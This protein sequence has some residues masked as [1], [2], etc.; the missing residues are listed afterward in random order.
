MSEHITE[1]IYRLVCKYCEHY[2]PIFRRGDDADMVSFYWP[3]RS[4]R[5]ACNDGAGLV[6]GLWGMRRVKP[7]H[8]CKK[9]TL[10]KEHER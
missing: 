6:F 4:R 8:T 1:R 7:E 5:G 10:R 3:A 2:K 9:F